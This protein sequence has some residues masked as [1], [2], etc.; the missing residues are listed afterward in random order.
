MR[1]L[2]IRLRCSSDRHEDMDTVAEILSRERIEG[3]S[4]YHPGGHGGYAL[5]SFQNHSV[6]CCLKWPL[7]DIFLTRISDFVEIS[8]IS[9]AEVQWSLPTPVNGFETGNGSYR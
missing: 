3:T 7:W 8:R 5:R 9:D 1:R 2:F 6:F 4:L